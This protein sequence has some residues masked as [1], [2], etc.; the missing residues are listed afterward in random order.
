MSNLILPKIKSALSGFIKSDKVGEVISL[1]LKTR[2]PLILHGRGGHGKSEM[3]RSVFKALAE[4]ED[5]WGIQSCG[6]GMTE[7]KLYGGLDLDALSR[8]EN[9]ALQFYPER[10]FL[11]KKYYLFEELNDAPP[12]VLLSFKDTITDQRLNNGHQT[13]EMKTL[14][15]IAATNKNP[16]EI[17][18]MG[19]TYEALM[20]RFP[21]RAVVEWD[22]YGKADFLELFNK[23]EK[24]DT[25][26]SQMKSLLA[27]LIAEAHDKGRW[28]SPR[29]SVVCMNLLKASAALHGRSTV[30]EDDFFAMKFVPGTEQLLEDLSCNLDRIRKVARAQELLTACE[31]EVDE[32]LSKMRQYEQ[33]SKLTNKSHLFLRLATNLENV[34]QMLGNLSL[35]DNLV[36]HKDLLTERAVQASKEA[37][38]L[39]KQFA[40]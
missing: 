40:S 8:S 17:C 20:D 7:D 29:T 18:E 25:V 35:P 10:S 22:S 11:N 12:I 28:I 24:G 23:I 9:K 27:Q 15:L 37:I 4:N 3:V 30:T 14:L 39:A 13:F 2:K 36:R 16:T 32:V 19:A 6:E 34:E 33:N 1:A 21:L 31:K 5:E 26:P 38:K